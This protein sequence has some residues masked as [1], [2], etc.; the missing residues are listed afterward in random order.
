MRANRA[1]ISTDEWANAHI[2]QS[3]ETTR[4]SGTDIHFAMILCVT[5]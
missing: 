1:H 5:F 3:H 4:C 2:D